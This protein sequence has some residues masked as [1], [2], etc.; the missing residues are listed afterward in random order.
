MAVTSNYN[1]LIHQINAFIRRYELN[2]LL[3][4]LIFLAAGMCSAFL[5]IA[6][7]EYFGNFNTGLRTLLFYFFIV[8]NSFLL[9]WLVAPP[10]IAYLRLGKTLS[11]EQAAE[12]IG[13]H[14]TDVKDKLLNTLQLKQLAEQ[15]IQH[16][17]IIEAS[18]N[19]KIE[20][21]R[22][23]SFPSAINFKT[24]RRFL[25][26]VIY[27]LLIILIIAAIAPSIL[28]ESTRRIIRHNE[29]FAPVAPFEFEVQNHSLTVVQGEDLKLDV[30]LK[31]SRL[32]NEVYIE[33]ADRSFKLTKENI[34]RFNYLFTNVQQRIVFRL[35]AN[36]YL[37]APYEI[38]V[39]Y[40]PSLLHFNV[41]L[42]YPAYLHKKNEVLA[43]TGELNIPAGTAVTWQLSTK[44]A[45]GVQFS[46]NGVNA[47]AKPAG[48]SYFEYAKS[49]LHNTHYTIIPVSNI[50]LRRDSVAYNIHVIA[51][52][53]PEIAVVQIKDSISTKA[54]YFNGKI[55]DDYGFSSLN[56]FGV[57][58]N[59]D[60]PQQKTVI[61]KTVKADLTKNQS[62]FFYYLNTADIPAKPGSTVSYYFEVADNDGVNGPKK[63]RSQEFTLQVPDM[64]QL[65]K[66]LNAGSQAVKQKMQSAIKLASQL[67]RETQQLNQSLFNKSSL[68]YDEKKQLENLMQKRKE[69]NDLIKDIQQ[70]NKK[71]AYNRQENQQQDA[72]LTAKQKEMEQLMNQMAD[73]K[74]QEM[75]KQLENL[76]QQNQKEAT[77]NELS[78]MQSDNQ[79]V[80]K[81]LNRMLELYKKLDF[82]QKLNQNINQLN[83]LAQQQQ[84][85]AQ[86]TGEKMASTQQLQQEQ[87][88][89]Q[90]KFN[91]L[92]KSLADLDKTNEQL[93]QKTNFK[94]PEPQSKQVEQQMEISAAQLQKNNHKSAQQAQQQA[95]Q[96]MQQMASQMKQQEQES[97]E[98]QNQLNLQQLRELV[99]NLVNSSFEQEKLMQRLRSISSNDASYVSLA[100]RQKD[101]KD[102]LKTAEDTLYAL[103]TRVPQIQAAVNQEI[104]SINEHIAS[105]LT[106]MDERRTPEVNRHQQYAMTSMN[107]LALMLSE[108]MNQLQR[109]MKN[110]KPGSGKKQGSL[111]QL[112]QQQQQLNQNMQ[113]MREQLQQ[114]G[115]QGKSAQS[116]TSE[117]LARMARQQ[118]MI[119]QAL[120]KYSNEETNPGSA[121]ASELNKIARAMEQTENDI[122]NKNIT[123][124]SLIRQQQI[125]SRL[126]E[127]EKAEQQ[128]EQDKQ[129]ESTAGK[130]FPPGYIKALQNYQQQRTKQTELLQT[131]PPAL[132]LYFKQRVKLYF[133]QLNAQ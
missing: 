131:V 15:D 11:H 14:F 74:T 119:R 61:R 8:L 51:D 48:N 42:R 103:S 13:L 64:Q 122:V 89:L 86:K 125:H 99:K 124:E 81:D 9:L 90:Q 36:G 47:F 46:L 93:D 109:M 21:L 23:V 60:H 107:N 37:S 40:K 56:F 129:R 105:A 87:Q 1:F 92:K 6:L 130:S 117:Q 24:N 29:Y 39:V 53:A 45:A 95:A 114:Q 126:L 97:E 106:L 75:L 59:P 120:E 78:E 121:G 12:I 82:D 128:R 108:V 16:R 132:N 123:N 65:D 49:I 112:S 127:A 44:N 5:I 3:R 7:C 25:K 10:L 116:S 38:K 30:K 31:G 22:P 98:Q 84:Q 62:S 80:K 41:Q 133:D 77:R 88:Q 72:D 83:Q 52:Q 79:S 19:Q 50:A 85:L 76:L 43:N 70:E 57:I 2:R 100:Q 101:I 33:M 102:N 67:E 55:R 96:Q 91:E 104:K 110:S 18:I 115:N 27:P 26:W 17:Q 63:V 54:L 94:N 34:S 32:P 20:V 118:Q 69:L 68:S 73:P 28:T 71:N 35:S 66:Q 58:N 113:R 111:S 4:G